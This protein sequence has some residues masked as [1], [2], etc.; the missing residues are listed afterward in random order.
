LSKAATSS[1]SRALRDNPRAHLHT[2]RHGVAM[3]QYPVSTIATRIGALAR[4]APHH[5]QGR[6]RTKPAQSDPREGRVPCSIPAPEP[7]P[8]VAGCHPE[9]AGSP[10]WRREEALAER[11]VVLHDQD[12]WI[13]LMNSLFFSVAR[14]C[15]ARPTAE[16]R[17]VDDQ[18]ACC[19]DV[20]PARAMAP[21]MSGL[22]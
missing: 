14:P 4:L 17:H 3:L 19:E 9:A 20:I 11:L 21:P 18:V 15:T 6:C 7:S 8:A 2:G 12:R 1:A 13:S 10:S 22:S 16:I 5:G